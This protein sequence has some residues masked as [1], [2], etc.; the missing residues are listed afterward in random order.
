MAGVL[1]RERVERMKMHRVGGSPSS[2]PRR[3]NHD[4]TSTLWRVFRRGL[5]ENVS[6]NP[7]T[8]N[9]FPDQL[10]VPFAL[11]A[12]KLLIKFLAQ[13]QKQGRSILRCLSFTILLLD[14]I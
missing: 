6:K 11:A 5:R 8:K 12:G 10:C 3:E 1:T 14:L 13:L 4:P 9:Y 7:T 2:P